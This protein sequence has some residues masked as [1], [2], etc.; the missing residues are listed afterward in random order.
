MSKAVLLLRVHEVLQLIHR[1][2]VLLDLV[3]APVAWIDVR[4]PDP[5]ARFIISF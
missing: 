5:R 1:L 4:E 3:L 2:D